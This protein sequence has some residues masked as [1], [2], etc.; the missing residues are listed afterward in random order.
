MKKPASKKHQPYVLERKH[1]PDLLAAL[2]KKVTSLSDPP[3]AT[4]AVVYEQL[5]SVDDLPNVTSGDCFH[6]GSNT[7]AITAVLLGV[8]LDEGRVSWTTTL[9][10]IFPDHASSMRSEYRDV[11][12]SDLLSHSAG[13]I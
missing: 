13:F 10:T 11:T 2:T 4:G 8:L 5:A 3:C 1:F 9:P 6:L 12:V 7:K